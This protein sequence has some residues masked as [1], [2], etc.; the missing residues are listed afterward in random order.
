[1]YVVQVI[2]VIYMCVAQF[3]CIL[4]KILKGCELLPAAASLANKLRTGQHYYRKLLV[5]NTNEPPQFEPRDLKQVHYFK[6]SPTANGKIGKDAFMTLHERAYML[7]GSIWSITT[8]K[9]RMVP[10]GLIIFTDMLHNSSVILLSFDTTFS[11]VDFYLC[12]E[13]LKCESHA[14]AQPPMGPVGPVPN[15]LTRIKFFCSKLTSVLNHTL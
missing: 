8:Y 4:R 10:C 11:L 5:D 3:I 7:P 13:L 6:S 9:D 12:R 14:W 2:F 1:M 15:F